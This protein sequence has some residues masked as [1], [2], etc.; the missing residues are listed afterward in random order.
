M[1]LFLWHVAHDANVYGQY[2]VILVCRS[3]AALEGAARP[4]DG[5]RSHIKLGTC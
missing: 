3:E 1:P 5:R 4:S 2:A